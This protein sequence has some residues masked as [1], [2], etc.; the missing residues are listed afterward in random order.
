M[1]GDVEIVTVTHNSA[2]ELREPL[3]SVERHLPGTRVVVVDSGS[4]DGTLEV[5]R[6][7]SAARV[8]ALDRNVGFGTA[9]NLGLRE[10][11]A[12]VAAL[13]NPDVE[14]LDRSLLEPAG[15]WS[16]ERGPRPP[17]GPARAELRREPPGHRPPRAR[18][19]DG[20]ADRDRLPL[21]AAAA[22]RRR[23]RAVGVG[24]A[25]PR[26]VGGRVRARGPDRHTARPRPLRRATVHVRRGPRPVPASPQRGRRDV[27][28]GPP[29]GSSTTAPTHPG[30]HSAANRSSG[31]PAP[32]E[33]SSAVVS[34]ARGSRSTTA[35]RRSRSSAGSRSS[36]WSGARPPA[37][38]ASCRRCCVLAAMDERRRRAVAIAVAAALLVAA[39]VLPIAL[40]GG[41]GPAKRAVAPPATTAAVPSQPPPAAQV[42]GASVNRI[43]NAPDYSDAQI[44]AQLTAL[45]QTGA[46][47]AR[48]D[49]L[50]E[51]AE[52]QPPDGSTHHYDWSFADRIVQA[53]AAHGLRWLPI[54][55][56]SAR[57]RSPPP[58]RTTLPPSSPQAYADY[59][60]A[61]AQR[62][63]P[64]GTFWSTHPELPAEPVDTYEIWNEPDNPAFWSPRPDAAAYAD[65]Y[66]AARAAIT[67][68]QP[69][70]R[71]IVG[72][73]TQPV[74]FSG[75]DARCRA[76]A[77]R[78]A[79]RGRGSTPTAA[80][81]SSVLSRVRAARLGARLAGARVGPAVRNRAR[82]DDKSAG[83][84]RLPARAACAPPTSS[85]RSPRSGTRTAASRRPSSTPG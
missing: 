3:S 42:F 73:L 62:Y 69:D 30:R 36:A 85:D 58:A 34:G 31:S 38:A 35:P 71:V 46:T 50:W 6:S 11:R 51:A 15:E 18:L 19:V 25:A 2:A 59:A 9:T 7:S 17:A 24:R 56:Y 61:L 70:A 82:L 72:G 83:S 84:A 64:G 8:I 44:D 49:A 67:S 27:V 29:P 32:G 10:V 48:S 14:L 40:T 54:V 21:R 12:P 33:R 60:A 20:P 4:S 26:R 37:S 55:D 57:G 78:R 16:P 81:R 65:L 74:P 23:A 66:S 1:P 77:A 43:F 5:A 39:V 47:V 28:P 79:R 13:L 63:G 45:A 22:S 53:L 80:R 68:V 76:V 52:P 41:G 75:G